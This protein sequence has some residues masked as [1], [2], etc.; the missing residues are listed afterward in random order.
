MTFD[1]IEDFIAIQFIAVS[2]LLLI[3]ANI[4]ILMYARTAARQG[5]IAV[6]NALGASRRRIV[7]QLFCEALVLAS[8]AAVFGVM[9]IKFVIQQAHGLM[10]GETGGIPFWISYDISS[11][12]IAVTAALTLLASVIAGVLPALKATGRNV[13]LQ[14]RQLS[15]GTDMQ[16]GR[17]WTTLIVVQVAVAVALLPNPVYTAWDATKYGISEP[18]FPSHEFLTARLE[19]DRATPPSATAAAY[20]RDYLVRYE[21]LQ[22]ELM[23]R[24]ETE[25]GVSAVT[26]ASGLP[27]E[28]SGARIEVEGTSAGSG[29][30]HHVR[31]LRV[32]VDFFEAFGFSTLTGQLFESGDLDAATER[33]VVNRAF[34][35]QILGGGNALGRRVRYVDEGRVESDP[36]GADSS[37]WYEIVGV[38]GNL[39]AQ[40][41]EPGE[42]E[43][44]LYHPLEAGEIYPEFA[45]RLRGVT[46]A[47]FA[48]RLQE[49]TI[50]LSPTLVVR[51]IM[52][53]DEVHRQQVGTGLV[54]GSFALL[55]LSVLLLSASGIYSLMSLAVARRR[56][57]I[58]I[59]TA[60]GADR[61]HIL[62]CIFARSVFQLLIGVVTGIIAAL[63]LDYLADG[64]MMAGQAHII[65]P[66]V[67]GL[68]MTAGLL[69]AIGP[70]RRGLRI[71]PAEALKEE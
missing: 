27:G 26:R 15:G 65:L 55:T 11:E 43:A 13:E 14:L 56:R 30:G 52:A 24:L 71:S 58:A 50:E 46:P 23:T 70:A 53:L 57:D 17:T 35:Q 33:V 3:C 41:I 9:T 22:K 29:A 31:Y 51:R 6:R 8:L 49:V 44:K 21:T 60:L 16:L 68:T 69:A 1:D 64:E 61:R 37:R 20:R 63:G 59:R 5:E 66:V 54:A 36:S 10:E 48:A 34:V 19:M 25:P 28:E 7:A 12:T 4:A 2:V 42:V 62:G 39:P 40:S 38:V 67:A 45:V 18:G 47:R 32:D